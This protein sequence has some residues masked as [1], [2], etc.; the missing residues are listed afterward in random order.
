DDAGLQHSLQSLGVDYLSK[1]ASRIGLGE[2]VRDAASKAVKL[3]QDNERNLLI[4]EDMPAV[5]EV[6]T[7]QLEVLGVKATFVENG[8]EALFAVRSGE[9]S[10][11]ITDLHMPEMDGYALVKAVRADDVDLGRHM[12]VIA[13]T[14]D[15]Q[16]A[17]RQVYMGHGFDECILKPVSLGQMRRLLVR[18]GFLG[19]DNAEPVKT[20]IS[21]PRKN[22]SAIDREA[23]I[24]QMG[25]FD[26]DA[27]EML[28]MF[29]DMTAPVMERLSKAAEASDLHDL[30]EAA[31]S[32]KGAARSAC[33]NA[34]GDIAAQI[35]DE[36]EDGHCSPDRI[37]QVQSE[38]TRAQQEIAA[39]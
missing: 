15:V 34:L 16:I 13:L 32:L 19:A 28:K 27:I 1:P 2:A 25:A 26:D 11:L 37:V 23:M 6:L 9:Y 39:L 5:R 12:P 8:R 31:H 36:A 21:A 4:A 33:L 10:V 7:R 20:N 17:Q 29:V 22:L 30:K 38:F 18:W 24:E 14:A 3:P 35:Q